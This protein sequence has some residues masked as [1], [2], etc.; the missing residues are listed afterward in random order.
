MGEEEKKRDASAKEDAAPGKQYHENDLAAK[1]DVGCL[2][3][4][5]HEVVAQAQHRQFGLFQ[6]ALRRVEKPGQTR[7]NRVD[8]E[9]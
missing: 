6:R 9:F 4:A 2:G 3:E 8:F 5:A 7:R 1:H